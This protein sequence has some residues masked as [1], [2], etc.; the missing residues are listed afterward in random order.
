MTKIAFVY[1]PEWEDRKIIRELDTGL[2]I[3]DSSGTNKRLLLQGTEFK[4]PKFSPDD[5]WIVFSYHTIWKVSL[6]GDSVIQL[7]DKALSLEPSWSSDGSKIVFGST[8]N[9]PIINR[10]QLWTVSSD[11]ADIQ[12]LLY[13]NSAIPGRYPWFTGS[14][15]DITFL[16]S[17]GA[18]ILDFS[19]QK[20]TLDTL[21]SEVYLASLNVLPDNQGF[22]YSHDNHVW[23]MSY[24]GTSRKRLSDLYARHVSVCKD[25]WRL[26]FIAADASSGYST[27]WTMDVSGHNL[28][29]LTNV[30][31]NDGPAYRP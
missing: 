1:V 11:G 5:K 3:M 27:I 8:E 4:Y 6:S 22:I 31:V 23:K 30:K 2:Y 16:A 28:R 25:G 26:L 9:S 15:E 10:Y 20:N 19:Q 18:R 21:A 12:Q 13:K 7:Y 17:P 29:Q 14:D 24:N